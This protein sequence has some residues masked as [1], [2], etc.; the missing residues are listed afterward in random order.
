MDE[1]RFITDRVKKIIH[2][3]SEK[4]ERKRFFNSDVRVLPQNIKEYIG[5]L[6][7]T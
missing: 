2:Y 5:I 6:L 4:Y 3:A 7:I 1:K